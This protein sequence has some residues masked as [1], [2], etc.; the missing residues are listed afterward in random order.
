MSLNKIVYQDNV[1]GIVALF[2]T[3]KVAYFHPSVKPYIEQFNR[4][5]MPKD[6]AFFED[7]ILESPF[8]A[9][10]NFHLSAPAIAFIETTNLCNLRCQHCYAWS[11]KKRDNELST[12][13]IKALIDEFEA[14]GVLQVFLTGGEL[15]AHKDAIE[16][17]QHARQKPFST[18][19][20]SN[21]LLITEEKLKRIPKGQ[22]FFV[23][24][25]TAVPERTVRGKMNFPK[26]RECFE[27][28]SQYGHVVRTAVS[29]HN[30]N[31]NDV[32]EIFQWCVDNGF[33]RPQWLETHPI[34]RALLNPHIILQPERLD[35]VF[36][37][38]E[39]CMDRFQGDDADSPHESLMGKKTGAF[40]SDDIHG[41]E[42]IKFCQTL[43]W[44][45][46][47]EKCG[48][49]TAYVNS[50]GEVFP[51]SNCMSNKMYGAG[52]IKDRSFQEIWETG[53]S[54]FRGKTFARHT[55]CQS[56]DVQQSGVWCQFRCPPL[57]KNVS[58]D[59]AGCGATEYLRLFMIKSHQYWTL[60]RRQGLKLKL[61]APDN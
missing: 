16:I 8:V 27:L 31:I 12:E 30:Q 28:M 17:I 43:E 41:V 35:E 52:N 2:P 29:V 15:F 57:A 5:D 39:R 49:S 23:S 53:F 13:R 58:G 51:C 1:G 45:T 44:A 21:G 7:F 48:R 47:Q 4:G 25:D 42:T 14:L 10:D 33:P 59:E 60:R 22:S 24:F 56:C 50:S 9:L 19:I 11:G 40:T 18:Q 32:E 55:V 3:G 36:A 37:I 46:Q 20:F 6:M 54:D 26:L 38:Y 61:I 34:G